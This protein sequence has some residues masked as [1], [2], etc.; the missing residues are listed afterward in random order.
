LVDAVVAIDCAGAHLAAALGKPLWVLK[1]TMDDWRWQIGSTASP[2]W[3][4]AHV[5]PATDAGE[6][7]EPVRLVR[8]DL[9]NYLSR[10]S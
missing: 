6:W 1:P 2:W 4:E 9:Q 5:F 7:H 8:Q 10:A 3:P